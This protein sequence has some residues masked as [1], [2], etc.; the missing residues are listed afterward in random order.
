MQKWC[1]PQGPH[2]TED[3]EFS[4]EQ[5]LNIEHARN[6]SPTIKFENSNTP[7]TNSVNENS[8]TG[9]SK[10]FT[11]SRSKTFF[12]S[13]G[14]S[15]GLACLA[16][17]V[18]CCCSCYSV[19]W[20]IGKLAAPNTFLLPQ[21][22]APRDPAPSALRLLATGQLK[23]FALPPTWSLFI[24]VVVALDELASFRTILRA[25]LD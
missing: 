12:S 13:V 3:R 10:M 17:C 24:F 16:S 8:N 18:L 11:V 20:T 9:F 4:Q 1:R 23:G 2:K 22:V 15:D 6:S 21:G 14:R 25:A 7:K 5:T 19:E